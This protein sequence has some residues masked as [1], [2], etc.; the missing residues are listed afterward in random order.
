LS[1]S[2]V[3]AVVA[4]VDYG[5]GNIASVTHS[6][7]ALGYR[8]LVSN[9]IEV[10]NSADLL[11]LPGVGAFPAVMQNLYTNDLVTYLQEQASQGQR[12]IGICLGMQLLTNASYEHSYTEGLGIIPGEFVQFP[13]RRCHIGWNTLE[14]TREDT[15]LQGSNGQPFYFNHSFM[16]SGADQYIR[17]MAYNSGPIPVVIRNGHVVGLQFHPEKSQ[18]AGRV[19]LQNV[20]SGLLHG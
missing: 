6:L 9:E 8:V 19:L 13:D 11:I 12:I 5:M 7:R 14:C 10:L 20:I 4:V 3:V 16:F 1:S 15:L 2:T 18:T 17:C